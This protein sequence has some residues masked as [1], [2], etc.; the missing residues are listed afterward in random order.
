[1]YTGYSKSELQAEITDIGKRY[2]AGYTN[3]A[4]RKIQI[5]H[6]VSELRKLDESTEA[7]KVQKAHGVSD[8]EVKA[9][10]R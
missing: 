3:D 9:V 8:S 4:Q 2:A 1:M 10:T 7:D 6:C 5:A